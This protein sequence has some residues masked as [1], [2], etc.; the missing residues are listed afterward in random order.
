[1]EQFQ[2]FVYD[3]LPF[4]CNYCKHQG[5][6]ESECQL[7][8]VNNAARNQE[9]ASKGGSEIKKYHDDAREILDEKRAGNKS[10]VVD[11]SGVHNQVVEARNFECQTKEHSGHLLGRA[12]AHESVSNSKL[13]H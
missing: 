13:H 12:V 3:N 2:K 6:N 4:Y 7:L 8:L 9:E 11:K 1:V 10:L 5:H